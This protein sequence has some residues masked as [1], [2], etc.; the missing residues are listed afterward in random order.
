MKIR[1]NGF[2]KTGGIMSLVLA[3]VIVTCHCDRIFLDTVRDDRDECG[4]E[5]S[6]AFPASPSGNRQL[7]ERCAFEGDQRG[8]NQLPD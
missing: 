8:W 2:L 1:K 5:D 3:A 7:R 4:G 6:A